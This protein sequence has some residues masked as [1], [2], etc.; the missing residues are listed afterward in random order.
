[1]LN[2]SRAVASLLDADPLQ[3]ELRA[4]QADTLHG[5]AVAFQLADI[6]RQ[7]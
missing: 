7:Q 6:H 5:A 1:M 4:L 3:D 2:L